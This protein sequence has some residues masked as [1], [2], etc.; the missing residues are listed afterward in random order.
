[1]YIFV[2]LCTHSLHVY[3]TVQCL[4]TLVHQSPHFS[5][6]KGKEEKVGGKLN[7][8]EL[9]WFLIFSWYDNGDQIKAYETRADEG[10]AGDMRNKYKL[11]MGKLEVKMPLVMS[12]RGWEDNIKIDI[13]IM[14]KNV[15]WKHMIR[16]MIRWRV[17]INKIVSLRMRYKARNFLIYT[18]LRFSR[19]TRHHMVSSNFTPL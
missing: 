13:N 3:V 11:L 2:C 7:K 15:D 5:L 18:T 1:M 6:I 9:R 4:Y 8:E 14:C 12:R 17:I 19:M 10:R 16:D